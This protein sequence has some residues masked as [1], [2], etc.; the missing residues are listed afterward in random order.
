MKQPLRSGYY[1]IA[2]LVGLAA[3]E[4][5]SQTRVTGLS[6]PASTTAAGKK[7]LVANAQP[8]GQPQ[9]AAAQAPRLLVV[10]IADQEK[11]GVVVM[12]ELKNFPGIGVA[13]MSAP[14]FFS[15]KAD[16]PETLVRVRAAYPELLMLTPLQLY[17]LS[18]SLHNSPEM[19]KA[20]MAMAE[21]P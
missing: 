18:E 15:V 20:G 7:A 11:A 17:S 14:G 4:G 21:K 2:L 3:F 10:Y 19:A 8:G 16:R 6:K 12:D 1:L 9:A 13:A 5:H